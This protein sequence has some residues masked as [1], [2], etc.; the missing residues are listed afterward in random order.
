MKIVVNCGGEK[1]EIACGAGKQHIRWLGLVV[2]TR[3]QKE[4]YPHSFRVPQRVLGPDGAT[5]RARQ[6]ISD[7]LNDGDEVT[8]EL[9]QGAAIPEDNFEDKEWFEEAY[10]PQSHLME[11]KFRWKVNVEQPD[12]PKLVRGDFIVD[13]RW[14]G[15]YLQKDY[16]GRFEIPVEP[17]EVGADGQGNLDWIASRKGP[18]GSCTYRFVMSNDVETICK[19]SPESFTA[20][21]SAHYTEFH[22]DVPIAPEPYPEIDSRPST[23]SSRDG[24]QVDPRFEQDW[25]AMRLKWVESFMKVRVR[26]VLTEFYAILI[27]L[28]D[29]YA[30]MGL[31]L[32]AHQHTIGMDDW[33]HLVL[34]CGLL[35]GQPQGG[36][37]WNECCAWFEEAAGIRDG[38]PYLAQRLSRSHYLELL[39]RTAGYVMCEHPRG[40]YVPEPGRPQM[41]L[42]EGLFRFITD[43]LIPV[44]DVYDDDPIRKDA[45]KNQNLVVIQQHRSSMRSVYAFL[46]HPWSHYSGERVVVPSTLK[47][48]LNFALE[49]LVE[50]DRAEKEIVVEGEGQKHAPTGPNFVE[51]LGGEDKLTIKQLQVITLYLNG[52]IQKVTSNH[53]EQN[54]QRALLFWEF[55]EVVMQSCRE[56]VEHCETPLHEGIPAFAQ[57]MLAFIGL[58]DMGEAA[59][60]EPASGED[61]DDN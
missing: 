59:L 7:V 53:P 27:D 61:N 47:Y 60:P 48:V 32:T 40:Q 41:P 1:I 54:D 51:A 50:A 19:A 29:S 35:R 24:A 6:A 13:R 4:R 22:W 2:A 5:L 9:R 30:F 38:R 31:D 42:D 52:T 17:V 8:V 18:P 23:A 36:L 14:Q 16:G 37:S 11:C 57:T 28:F 34:N 26:D 46:S 25:D 44:M 15:V 3:I 56:L 21:R 33:K 55:F 43:I 45:V 20:D 39:M 12:I 49:K 10:G 58:V